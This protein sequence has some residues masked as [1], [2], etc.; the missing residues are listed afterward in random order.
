[1]KVSHL[2]NRFTLT[3]K[4]MQL[5]ADYQIHQKKSFL[6][7]KVPW[8]VF[9]EAFKS[10]PKPRPPRVSVKAPLEARLAVQP[11][12]PRYRVI[13]VFLGLYF[14]AMFFAEYFIDRYWA[15]TQRVAGRRPCQ[16]GDIH[17]FA[18][19]SSRGMESGLW[20]GENFASVCSVDV[21]AHRGRGV[22][23]HR[24]NRLH[25]HG[26][27]HGPLFV[28]AIFG[29]V[30]DYRGARV[31]LLSRSEALMPVETERRA[32]KKQHTDKVRGLRCRCVLWGSLSQH[33]DG[34]LSCVLFPV[35]TFVILR[36]SFLQAVMW[37][38]LFT[39][40]FV[41]RRVCHLDC[42]LLPPR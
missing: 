15:T 36:I 2:I 21:S 9:S 12:A 29:G 38:I 7:G 35:F 32:A 28:R 24:G 19:N 1:M 39:V 16:G 11:S 25:L 41:T 34:I 31:F 4:D 27:L 33:L 26:V 18:V 5:E 37:N 14:L 30:G 10:D 17:G 40:S 23:H 3:F 20:V 42:L 13:F 6:K 22:V 8:W